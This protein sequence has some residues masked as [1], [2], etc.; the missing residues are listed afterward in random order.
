MMNQF[1]PTESPYSWAATLYKVS[2]GF[3]LLEEGKTFGKMEATVEA[4]PPSRK[5]VEN[6]KPYPSFLKRLT[7]N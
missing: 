5:R 4:N 2:E 7:L 3:T 1:T 6:K